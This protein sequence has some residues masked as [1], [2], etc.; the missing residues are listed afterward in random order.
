V[1]SRI[2]WQAKAYCGNL[3]LMIRDPFYRDIEERLSGRLDPDLFERC[4]ADLLRQIHPTLVP[5]RGGSDAGMDGAIADEGGLPMPLVTTTA[6]DVIG[7]LHRSLNSYLQDGGPR[8][9]AVV[10]TSQ[11][12]TQRRRRNLERAAEE[13]GFTL[14]Q[15]HDQSAFA[16]LLYHNPDWCRELL[17][18]T[19]S[20][21][22]LS[23]MPL[24]TRPLVGDTL[25]GSSDALEWL[26]NTCGDSLL[27]GQPGSGKTFLL[28]CF[29]KSAGALF[30]HTT[31]LEE[32]A[33][34]LR[35][36]QP[37]ALIVDDAHLHIDFLPQL[38]R[39]R[40]EMHTDVHI[41]AD[42]WPG[43][44]EEVA[45]AL[46]IP[47]TSVRAINLLSRDRIAEIIKGTGIGGPRKLILEIMNQSEGKPGLA[48]TLS[49][50]CLRGDV[51][52]LVRGDA[53]ANEIA[54]VFTRLMGGDV[55]SLL[56]SFAVAGDSGM[57]MQTVAGYLTVPL[58]TVRERVSRL[59]AGG[60]LIEIE[61]EC[62]AVRPPALRHALVRDAFF[63]GA[64]SLPIGPLLAAS[65][66]PNDLAETIIGARYRG[67]A[68]PERLMRSLVE[69]S[70][71]WDTRAG[72]ARLGRRQVEWI[73]SEHPNWLHQ[74]GD[75]ALDV[76]PEIGLPPLFRAAVGDI[77]ILSANPE[78]P[79]RIISD[80]I[81]KASPGTPVVMERRRQLLLAAERWLETGGDP[82]IGVH[83]LAHSLSPKFSRTD[84]EPGSGL[85]ITISS[86]F[87]T[88][89]DVRAIR[90]LWPRVREPVG[91]IGPEHWSPLRE[92]VESWA[93]RGQ[94]LQPAL[95]TE[96]DEFA[97]DMVC[98]LANLAEDHP[99]VVHWAR[100]VADRRRFELSVALDPVFETLF[101]VHDLSDWR[102]AE[103]EQQERASRLAE[104]WAR[105]EPTEIAEKILQCEREARASCHA[106]PHW[107]PFV[108]ERI[109]E[110]VQD[111]A[112]WLNTF[113]EGGAPAELVQP[114]LRRIVQAGD[115]PEGRIVR[116]CISDEHHRI[117]TAMTLLVFASTSSDLVELALGQLGGAASWVETTCL[118]GEFPEAVVLRLLSHPD[119]AI[120]SA[121]AIGEWNA[122]P[123]GEVRQPLQAAWRQA[124]L[125]CR[126][127][128]WFL[129][130]TLRTDPA[131]AMEWLTD[132]LSGNKELWRY[133][134]T[135]DA[136]LGGLSVEDR[137]QLIGV[138]PA[139]LFSPETVQKIVGND[140]SMYRELLRT[141]RLR[142]LHLAP[143]IGLPNLSDWAAKAEL[144]LEAGYSASDIADAVFAQGWS[145][146][147]NES[148]M[149]N[150]WV[151]R[152]NK[153]CSHSSSHVCEIGRIGS[154][155]A[156][157]RRDL[158]IKL[159]RDEEVRGW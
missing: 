152:F 99:G 118:R 74:V 104:E 11:Q 8:K 107:T 144:A 43:S 111:H 105:S 31:D 129:R 149:W 81:E 142:Q 55:T 37:T 67:A 112:P 22:A 154:E 61:R 7:N 54:S 18:I 121:T 135:I 92:I 97:A 56:A 48:V 24:P 87:V 3:S 79:L 139:D 58:H 76:A 5:I 42:S 13:L 36:E 106:W 78:H 86:G 88:P 52:R 9:T 49:N 141:D 100:T 25:V 53:L 10:A 89:E 77:R 73:A 12:L 130:E 127:D 109:A 40:T 17:G 6:K 136:A 34:G 44:H 14:H 90:R 122:D 151:N 69:Q 66:D 15:T 41:I 131:L 143:L 59:A 26:E 153:L 2:A 113:L 75:A 45:R 71:S 157:R 125:R 145:W 96:A 19:G 155:S 108:C 95:D 138:L 94:P 148:S 82:A 72:Y 33:A 140:L 84:T 146:N 47:S 60:V 133:D 63:G 156:A 16:D 4:A 85:T 114:F 65:P 126:G 20:P 62:L 91:G 93:F 83:G 46:D 80:W 68:V 51:G 120:A 35:A 32:I 150:D 134:E 115:D 102:A 98:D 124:V 64:T 23:V 70:P 21:P 159:E 38:R 57:T 29:A 30:V 28:Y 116:R 27:V 128:E 117:A 119:D 132:R 50:L 101:P 39:L 123:K 147:G 137:R 158:A 103:A 1:G 110:L